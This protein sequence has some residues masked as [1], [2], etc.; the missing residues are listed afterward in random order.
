VEK[1]SADKHTQDLIDEVLR[2][3]PV[4]LQV[5]M[6]AFRNRQIRSGKWE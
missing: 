1:R 5:E 4:R 6:I 3:D 2:V